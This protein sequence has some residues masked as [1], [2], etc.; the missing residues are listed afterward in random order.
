MHKQAP[1]SKSCL[2]CSSLRHKHTLC[3]NACLIVSGVSWN[4]PVQRS[5]KPSVVER[6]KCTPLMHQHTPFGN[7]C[8]SYQERAGT[9]QCR[10][11][12]SLLCQMEEVH[13]TYAYTYSLQH[14]KQMLPSTVTTRCTSTFL[15][16][17]HIRSELEPTSAEIGEAFYAE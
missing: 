10:E 7:L 12:C 13:R 2:L 15:S 5:T 4:P 9:H 17:C 14:R 11:R 6:R 1:S 3:R 8:V 16:V